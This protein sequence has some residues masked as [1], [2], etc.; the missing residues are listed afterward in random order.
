MA[1]L[2][3]KFSTGYDTTGLTEYVDQMKSEL[4]TKATYGGETMTKLAGQ[5]M[6]GVKHKEQINYLDIDAILS[7][8]TGCG[9]PT[10]SGEVYFPTKEVVVGKVGQRIKL[11]PSDLEQFYTQKFLPKGSYYEELPFNTE[12]MDLYT[13]KMAEVIERKLWQETSQFDGFLKVIEATADVIDGNPDNIPSITAANILSILYKQVELVPTAL[14]GDDTLEVFIEPKHFNTMLIALTNANLF[15]VA[16][17]PNAYTSKSE[18]I[19]AFGLKVTALPGLVGTNA[20]VTSRL[21]NYVIAVDETSDTDSSIRTWYDEDTELIN[22]RLKAKF[23]TQIKFGS[24]LV[25]FKPA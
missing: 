12:F 22:I 9:T 24:E 16:V 4:Y 14:F 15:H 17:S 7:A 5:I 1:K 3:L 25:Y 2:N 18:F 21:S 19:P 13:R 11:C 20:I 6:T 10:A 23:G 8:D